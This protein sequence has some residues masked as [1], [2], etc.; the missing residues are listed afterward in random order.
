[1]IDVLYVGEYIYK[2]LWPTALLYALLVA[3]AILG[4]RDWKRAPIGATA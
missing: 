1:V 4:L 2:Q 3:L